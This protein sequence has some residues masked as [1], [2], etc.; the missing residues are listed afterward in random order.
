MLQRRQTKQAGF[1]LIELLLYVAL[2]GILLSSVTAFFGTT[3]DARLKNHS[4]SEVNDQG[5]F[6]M[7]AMVQAARNATSIT[8]PVATASSSGFTVVVPTGSLSPTIFSVSG[9]VLQIKEGVGATV[10]LTNNKVTVSSLTVTNLTRSGTSG[11][12]QISLTLSRINPSGRNE[13]DYQRTF[14]TSVG[15]RP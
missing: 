13:Y 5:T 8:S 7:D 2:I 6:A 1:T 3:L 11:I 14:T 15:L 10:P 4:V 9:G 12:L